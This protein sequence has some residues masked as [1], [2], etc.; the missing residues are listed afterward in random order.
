MIV[1]QILYFLIATALMTGL[2]GWLLLPPLRNGDR[3]GMYVR[4]MAG[5]AAKLLAGAGIFL[6]AWKVFAWSPTVSAI[7]SV[8]AYTVALIIVAI[9]AAQAIQQLMQQSPTP[10]K[11]GE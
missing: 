3:E 10:E 6:L 7:G 1:L 11:E 2:G 8:A 5:F 4:M 9:L